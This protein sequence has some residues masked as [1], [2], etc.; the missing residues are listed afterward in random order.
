M[1]HGE[2]W[3]PCIQVEQALVK[4]QGLVWTVAVI[5]P[6]IA[7]KSWG[8]CYVTY[9]KAFSQGKTAAQ[10]AQAWATKRGLTIRQ[11]SSQSFDIEE[12]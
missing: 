1:S 2:S 5:H 10:I 3:A 4:G 8:H 9:T 12:N 7:P 11:T 6:G